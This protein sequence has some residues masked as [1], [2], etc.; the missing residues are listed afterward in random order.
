MD[1]RTNLRKSQ[2]SKLSAELSAS[3][4]RLNVVPYAARW[5]FESI[6]QSFSR[7]WTFYQEIRKE[8]PGDARF[9]E[10]LRVAYDDLRQNSTSSKYA[11]LLRSSDLG[12]I[13][14]AYEEDDL[15]IEFDP[16]I[17]AQGVQVSPQYRPI[18]QLSAGQRCTAVFPILLQL[19]KAPLLIDQPEDNLD[20]R[21]IA[22]K[23][24]ASILNN[25]RSR[26]MLFTSHNANLVVMGDPEEIV[27]FE[28]SD[29]IGRIE[30]QGFLAHRDSRI[31]P[32]VLDIL[33]GGERAL[34]LRAM[35]YGRFRSR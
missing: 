26:Q 35:K 29:G 25:K 18:D 6:A 21:H 9:H 1:E 17:E 33:D 19:E 16:K 8:F 10:F 34:E 32:F 2:V 3:G 27:A 24:A 28:A 20:N 31:T 7:S 22:H 4:V 13:L 30:E 14:D 12:P 5:R 15:A 11:S 23:I